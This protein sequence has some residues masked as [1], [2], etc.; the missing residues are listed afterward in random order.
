MAYIAP[1]LFHSVEVVQTWVTIHE[2]EENDSDSRKVSLR[3]KAVGSRSITGKCIVSRYS[4]EPQILI[5][6]A[7]AMETLALA[8]GKITALAISE[9][10]ARSI[11]RWVEPF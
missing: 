1:D 10:L 6:V 9:E 4:P 5:A 8:Q 11:T 2:C 3:L 7:K